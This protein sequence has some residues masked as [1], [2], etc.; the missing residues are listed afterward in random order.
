MT[1]SPMS[2]YLQP[3]LS[4][5]RTNQRFKMIRKFLPITS[6]LPNYN[7]SQFRGDLSAGVTVGVMLIPQGMAYALIAGLPAI[8]GLYASTIPLIIYAL[9]GTSRQLAVGP[10][11]MISLLTATGIG[12]IADADLSTYILLA[13]TLALM[14]GLI[15]C[16]LGLFRLGFIINFLSHPV[17]SGFTSAAAIIIGF[18]QLKH[19]LGIDI[20]RSQFVLNIVE[21]VLNQMH[22]INWVTVVIGL[23]GV[24]I[25][26]LL[27]KYNKSIPGA[28]VV[29]ILGILGVY[30]FGLEAYDVGIVGEVPS[31][32]PALKVPSLDSGIWLDLLPIAV[33]I[34]FIGFMESIA[35]AKAIQSR[36]RDYKID[37]NQEF[38]AIGSA[39]IG[40]AFM[41]SFPVAGGFSRTAV[42]DQA[43]AKSGMASIISAVI[44]MLTLLF[45]TS[46]FYYLPKA[47]LAAVIMVAVF[48][49]IDIKE[50]F[51][52]WKTHRKDFWMLVATFLATLSMGIEYGILIGVL[53]SIGMMVFETSRP[54]VAILGKVPKMPFYRNINRFEIIKERE[55]LL[56][57]RFDARLYFANVTFFKELMD[58]HIERKG[59]KLKAIIIN[60]ESI[61]A[62]DSSAIHALRE[63]SQDCRT[64]GIEVFFTG[65]RGPVRDVM[66]RGHLVAQFGVNN[67]FMNVHEAV[68]WYDT[69]QHKRQIYPGQAYTLQTNG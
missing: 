14:V 32:L 5:H 35:V 16:L 23:V 34:A 12:A 47:I 19:L 28:L 33:T 55:D 13:S 25:I 6:W 66:E 64:R 69:D 54:H 41:Q 61:S 45:L 11:A 17:I 39:N 53:L 15:Q 22:L 8:Y 40:A 56:I 43:G 58:R 46:L 49:L 18:S 60:S 38:L 1:L 21:N 36:H 27:R 63:L 59:Q 29:V 48:G 4:E 52:L 44:V 10:V 3:L 26:M 50:A 7:R 68:E 2:L 37:S 30:S 31:G 20:P 24:V 57:F 67:F 9:L 42:N 65:V 51:D 62:I